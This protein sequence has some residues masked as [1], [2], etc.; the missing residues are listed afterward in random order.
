[1]A[2]DNVRMALVQA[3][4]SAPPEPLTEGAFRRQILVVGGGLSGL[5]AAREAS[6]LRHEVLLVECAGELGRWSRKWSWRMPHRPP[7][8]DPQPNDI[9]DPI[10]AITSD[11]RITVM[12]EAAITKTEGMPGKFEV[13]FKR[14]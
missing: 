3:A 7:Y 12:T 4:N 2:A 13:E 1:M 11:P 14:Q 9:Q 10:A 6:R 8:R 5:T